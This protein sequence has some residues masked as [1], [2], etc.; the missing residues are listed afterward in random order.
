MKRTKAQWN[1]LCEQWHE[2]RLM[3]EYSATDF[4]RDK[5]VVRARFYTEYAKWKRA[6]GME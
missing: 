2:A 5:F 3:G 1:T 6:R 4:C